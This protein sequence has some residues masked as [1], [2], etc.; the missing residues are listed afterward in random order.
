LCAK[1]SKADYIAFQFPEEFII[2][3]KND[4]R[5]LAIMLCPPFDIDKVHRE[6][7]V[8]PSDAL[9]KWVGR[10]YKKDIFTYITLEDLKTINHEILTYA[11][12]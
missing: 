9:Y 2:V 4:L 8:K 11:T 6:N 3:S 5:E 12:S 7:F 10:E 1:G